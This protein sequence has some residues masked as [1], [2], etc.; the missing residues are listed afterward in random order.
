[1]DQ[2]L[3]EPSQSNRRVEELMTSAHRGTVAFRAD[4]GRHV[5]GTKTQVPIFVI[6][7]ALLLVSGP[8]WAHHAMLAQFA[9]NKPITLRG[10][11]TKME[12]QNPHGWIYLDV[13]NADGNVENWAIETGNPLR[14]ERGGLR[15]TDFR[16]GIE[17]IV[18]AFAA[19]NGSRTAAGWIVAFPDREAFPDQ[20]A[21]FPLGR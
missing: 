10:T 9:V 17:I 5:M 3:C 13:K 6:G 8:A 12:W 15:K 1:M 16:P 11:L 20:Q 2:N 7:A 14:M 18:G 19:K 21:S 4:V